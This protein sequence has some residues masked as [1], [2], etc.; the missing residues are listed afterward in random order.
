MVA[1]TLRR[2]A[3]EERAQARRAPQVQLGL[4]VQREQQEQREQREQRE[5]QQGVLRERVT[6][7]N[8]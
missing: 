3:G 5:Q 8:V 6:P 4:Q 7:R 2:G 1:T